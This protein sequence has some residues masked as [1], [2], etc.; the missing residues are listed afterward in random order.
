MGWEMNCGNGA[1]VTARYPRNR[2]PSPSTFLQATQEF[3]ADF[4][5]CRHGS[6]AA[7][8]HAAEGQGYEKPKGLMH[9]TSAT[10]KVLDELL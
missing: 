6:N 7:N 2:P 8:A 9:A 3:N 5:N 4:I 1:V 10:Q